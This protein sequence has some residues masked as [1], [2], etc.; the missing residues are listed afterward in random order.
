MKQKLQFFFWIVFLFF[1]CQNLFAQPL[2]VGAAAGQTFYQ[3][4]LLFGPVYGGNKFD[5]IE[6]DAIMSYH[7]KKFRID[8]SA[9]AYPFRNSL[10]TAVSTVPGMLYTATRKLSAKSNK[11][12]L[13]IK[14][15]VYQSRNQH[16]NCYVGL[17]YTIMSEHVTQW[18][19]STYPNDTAK[20]KY[21]DHLINIRP[22]YGV[23]LLVCYRLYK[24][25]FV[26]FAAEF[27]A[28]IGQ[29]SDI[30]DKYT[31][32]IGYVTIPSTNYFYSFGISY[33]FLNKKSFPN[34]KK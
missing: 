4:W 18:A 11:F 33:A 26:N 14:Y 28:V 19:I 10:D 20:F 23:N 2:E 13:G 29:H 17:S 15:Q 3:D 30:Y 7:Y 16:W 22:Y 1:N 31:R 9:A 27:S 32:V 12:C 34:N 5:F 6:K 8:L 21:N 24:N 25:I